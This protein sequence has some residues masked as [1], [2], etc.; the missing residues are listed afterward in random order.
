MRSDRPRLLSY[1]RDAIVEPALR[2]DI[3]ALAEVRRPALLHQIFGA[4]ATSPAQIV[5]LQKLQGR[6][7]DAGALETIASY[8]ELLGTAYLVAA[9]EKH[10]ARPARRSAPPKLV[11]LSNALLAAAD[12]RGIPEPGTDPQRF[13]AWVENACIAHALN[14]GQR[15]TYW[16]EEPLEVDA[17]LDG[18]WGTWAVEVKTGRF[19]A[20]DLKGL[21][22]FTRRHTACRP[23]I[24]CD[25]GERHIAER[26]GLPSIDWRTFLVSGPPGR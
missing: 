24:V 26:M 3:L 7:Q 22:E 10:S 12:P 18:S 17:V 4:C 5:S 16:R 11:T 8:L 13:G 9:L 19:D 23:L 14:R 20:S 2:K 6:L 15:V 21:L 25:P 1:L